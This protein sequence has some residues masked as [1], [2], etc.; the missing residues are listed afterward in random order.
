MCAYLAAPEKREGHA[1]R[2]SRYAVRGVIVTS[3]DIEILAA[4]VLQMDFAQEAPVTIIRRGN[5]KS[6]YRRLSS[7]R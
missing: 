2:G 6:S 3:I 7:A 5:A 1:F 4:I